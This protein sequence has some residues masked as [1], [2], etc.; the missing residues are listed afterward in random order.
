MVAATR[1]YVP[2]RP[3]PTASRSTH[4]FDAHTGICRER[5]ASGAPQAMPRAG[6]AGGGRAA[7][8]PGRSRGAQAS[9]RGSVRLDVPLLRARASTWKKGS[10]TAG[11]HAARAARR[12]PELLTALR[13][14]ELHLTAIKLLAPQLTRDNC[15]DWIRAARHLSVKQV[16]HEG[17][18]TFV[19]HNGRRCGSRD[20]PRVR[21]SRSLGAD[22]SAC[23]RS[24]HP[25]LPRTQPRRG[26]TD[27][28]R[29]S[30]GSLRAMR[31]VTPTCFETSRTR[32]RAPQPGVS[33][34][35]RVPPEYARSVGWAASRGADSRPQ[36]RTGARPD[37]ER[38]VLRAG[39]NAV[40]YPRA[41]SPRRS[42]RPPVRCHPAWR[43]ARPPARRGRT[44]AGTPPV[45]GHRPSGW[46][47]SLPHMMFPIP[48]AWRASTSERGREG[49]AD[50]DVSV[51]V[52][53][54]L[55][56]QAPR[57]VAELGRDVVLLEAVVHYAP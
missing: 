45:F 15:R 37:L 30:H 16:Q 48:M 49:G 47:K 56:R 43:R 40:R 57:V 6:A 21:A 20:F 1:C 25:S 41:A 34:R 33:P 35:S 55:H 10:R 26:A 53:A 12:H 39:S 3:H 54:G 24:H 22:T 18:C 2:A 51:E 50:E 9:S 19:S 46:G 27:L 29:A 8:S 36:W 13:R 32:S 42:R 31:G 17:R 52:L 44:A 5:R 38:Q 4:G 28:R 14:G 23:R 11:S 7:R